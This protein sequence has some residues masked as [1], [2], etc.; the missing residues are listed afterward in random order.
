MV[1]KSSSPARI[2]AKPTEAVTVHAS[3]AVSTSGESARLARSFSATD[4][5]PAGSVI[6]V[7]PQVPHGILKHREPQPQDS[8]KVLSHC[9]SRLRPSL[10]VLR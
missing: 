2:D 7:S 4:W 1:L 3:P 10:F 8:R 5:T 6:G 9:L